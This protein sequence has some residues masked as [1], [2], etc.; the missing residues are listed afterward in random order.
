MDRWTLYN[1]FGRLEAN[2]N[3]GIWYCITVCRRSWCRDN[4]QDAVL[5]KD[6]CV[7]CT[8]LSKNL[9]TENCGRKKW[10][11][12]SLERKLIEQLKTEYKDLSAITRKISAYTKDILSS[13][14]TKTITRSSLH[15]DN[16]DNCS[17]TRESATQPI[18]M[19]YFDKS[20]RPCLKLRLR[21]SQDCHQDVREFHQW[22][23]NYCG[24]GNGTT[25]SKI[26]PRRLGSIEDSSDGSS[27]SMYNYL[28]FTRRLATPKSRINDE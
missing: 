20:G 17:S 9:E 8:A 5:V 15:E 18:A 12:S 22:C 21:D 1:F 16:N 4:C 10:K 27:S 13:I 3:F 7:S 19:Q 25:T 26:S 6:A 23:R 11:G 14:T 28:M 2:G 24:T